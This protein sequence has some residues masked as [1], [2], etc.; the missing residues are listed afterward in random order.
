M[1]E[2]D[3]GKVYTRGKSFRA[4]A[5]ARARK[6]R[7][8]KLCLKDYDLYGHVLTV[9]DGE[10]GKNFLLPLQEDILRAVKER[11]AIGKGVDFAR[12]SKNLLSSQAMCFNL[13]VPL[14]RDKQLAAKLFN[15]LIGGIDS[16]TKRRMQI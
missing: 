11:Q 4:I 3:E 14:N 5:E 7:A 12:T 16:Y 10:K 1:D 13:F 2:I 6:Y 9:K 15:F 8:E